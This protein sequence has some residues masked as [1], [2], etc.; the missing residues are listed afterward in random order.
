MYR[1]RI[2]QDLRDHQQLQQLRYTIY[3]LEKAWLNAKAYPAELES[4]HFDAYATHFLAED[5]EGKILGGVR[6]IR[7][8]Y[9][10][11]DLP[12]CHHPGYPSENRLAWNS[13]EISRLVVTPDRRN[14]EITR[15]LCR[16]LYQYAREQGIE[17]VY[18]V[19][20][21]RLIAQLRRL[22]IHFT[23]LGLAHHY[24]GA[25]TLPARLLVSQLRQ[26]LEQGAAGLYHWY[27][28]GMSAESSSGNPLFARNWAFIPP[29][30]Q[31]RLKQCRLLLAGTGL[32]SVVA[33]VAIRT[34][35]SELI[36]AD[37]DQVELTN[38]NR[39]AFTQADLACNKAEALA[40]HLLTIN[41]ELRLEVHPH[42]LDDASLPELM[43]RCDM[44]INTID[45]DH[46][47]FLT[48]N[49]LAQ[50]ANKPV[51]FP[52]NLGWGGGCFAF[53]RQSCSLEQML[54]LD[55]AQPLTLHEIKQRLINHIGQQHHPAYL[56]PLVQQLLHADERA[57]AH[58]PQLAVGAQL[59]AALV[60]TA[61]VALL[62]GQCIRLAPEL[63][64]VDLQTL[65]AGDGEA[66][67]VTHEVQLEKSPAPE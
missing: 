33:E 29:S 3:C 5:E 38:L 1:C 23:P 4:D 36:I 8:A 11:H 30:L 9:S 35:F 28:E 64:A 59:S 24:F 53:T 25:P 51:L 62:Q 41:P 26:Q 7:N 21:P 44:V 14:G 15:L 57:W 10:P 42:F 18:I 46:P 43:D 63:N 61:A 40:R 50:Q 39:Q 20:E 13:A 45:F 67:S 66:M 49:R 48:C 31:Q 34:G 22:A 60:V 47:A 17:Q 56:Q 37:G 16:A 27:H 32:G 12:V 19:S 58:D 65:W 52:L 55:P 6:L 54:D 2:A